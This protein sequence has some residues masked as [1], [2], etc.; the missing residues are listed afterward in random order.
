ML[1]DPAATIQKAITKYRQ[2][3]NAKLRQLVKLEIQHSV[4]VG[5]RSSTQPT[6]SAIA[7]L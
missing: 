1:E 4:F 3:L 7:L 5:F 2:S 6:R